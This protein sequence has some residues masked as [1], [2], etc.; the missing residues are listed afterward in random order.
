MGHHGVGV[1]SIG[2]RC[3][4]AE[5]VDIRR[6]DRFLEGNRAFEADARQ[7]EGLLRS[8]LRHFLYGVSHALDAAVLGSYPIYVV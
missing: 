8:R 2:R 6:S 4:V 5:G 3:D 7:V 1:H